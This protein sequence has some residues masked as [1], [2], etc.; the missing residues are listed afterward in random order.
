LLGVGP[1]LGAILST[2]LYILMKVLD[3]EKVNGTQDRDD[4]I[5]I[6]HIVTRPTTSGSSS[7]DHYAATVV[8]NGTH[9]AFDTKNIV[10]AGSGPL[11]PGL[12][13]AP[14]TVGGGSV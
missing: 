9:E 2:G 5:L 3:Y 13:A 6:A 1:F 4:T 11:S 12:E 14:A 10:T 7:T 8:E